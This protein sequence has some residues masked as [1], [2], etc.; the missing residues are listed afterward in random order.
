MSHYTVAVIHHPHQEIEEL[1]AP[2]SE[3]L[4]V[5][6]YISYTKAQAIE[7]VRKY[8]K[9]VDGLSDEECYAKMAADYEDDMKDSDGNLYSTYNPQSKWDWWTEGGR[10]GGLLRRKSDGE[11]CDSEEI[12]NLD[13]AM[14]DAEFKRAARFWDVVV[15]G[16]PQKD[17]EEIRSI[18]TPEYYKSH[19]GTKEKYA[20]AMAS[21][22][23]YAVLTP[24]G[25]WHAPGEMGWWGCS[26]ESGDEMQDWNEHYMERFIESADP[27]DILT[28]VDCH[29]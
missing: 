10:W 28:I 4:E 3:N 7:H 2:Y 19:Y 23:T 11:E 15:E 14:D 21:F 13:F 8:W 12:G 29:I 1:L 22:N 27:N 5:P 26:S 17:G 24:D 16:A 25:V 6:K 9:D 18:W 20:K